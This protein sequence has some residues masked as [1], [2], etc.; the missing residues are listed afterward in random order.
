MAV[1]IKGIEEIKQNITIRNFNE[2]NK[3]ETK[4]FNVGG[5]PWSLELK[6][7]VVDGFLGVRLFSKEQ[8]RPTNWAIIA[9]IATKVVSIKSNV[10]PLMFE[11]QTYVFDRKATDWGIG[12]VIPWKRLIDPEQGYVYNN[13]CKIV[14]KVKSSPMLD[15]D[16][17]ERIELIPID[18]C[19]DAS[20]KVTF[21]LKVNNVRFRQYLLTRNQNEKLCMAFPSL[22]N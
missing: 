1:N 17:N 11:S 9:S 13:T 18:K 5:N 19:C 15:E 6:K 22:Q 7:L 3:I 14:V 21:R 20:T 10:N 8:S 16:N 2:F 4:T 12:C